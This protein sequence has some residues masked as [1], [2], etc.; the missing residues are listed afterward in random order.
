MQVLFRWRQLW[1]QLN[2]NCWRGNWLRFYLMW[3][4]RP[5]H[6]AMLSVWGRWHKTADNFYRLIWSQSGTEK[7]KNTLF[8][9]SGSHFRHFHII[10][11]LCIVGFFSRLVLLDEVLHCELAVFELLIQ[12]LVFEDV[13]SLIV[14]N[15][16][17][18][19]VDLFELGHYLFEQLR[20]FYFLR[21]RCLCCLLAS[22][23]SLCGMSRCRGF[24]CWGLLGLKLGPNLWSWPSCFLWSFATICGFGLHRR[25]PGL[26]SRWTCTCLIWWGHWPWCFWFVVISVSHRAQ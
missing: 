16:G 8:K 24:S 10:A 5:S 1:Q 6:P 15:E 2:R 14:L 11:P 9:Q 13:E 18:L 25:L 7:L 3:M 17:T 26:H 20:Y 21:D 23:H 12:I 19:L 22:S 4:S